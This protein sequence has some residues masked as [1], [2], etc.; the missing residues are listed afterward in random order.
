[1]LR[2]SDLCFDLEIDLVDHVTLR[3]TCHIYF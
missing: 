2:S 1:M 3:L